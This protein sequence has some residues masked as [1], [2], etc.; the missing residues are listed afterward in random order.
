M[1]LSGKIGNN[2][3]SDLQLDVNLPKAGILTFTAYI[4]SEYNGDFLLWYLDSGDPIEGISGFGG[5][6]TFSF[7]IPAGV[8]KIVWRY[9]KNLLISLGDD[10][11][12]VDNIL[13]TNYQESS[14]L[15]KQTLPNTVKLWSEHLADDSK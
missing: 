4:N 9:K 11:A 15:A 5:P 8:H 12:G 14:R 2:S 13:L 7:E 6:I 1:A 10:L 3:N